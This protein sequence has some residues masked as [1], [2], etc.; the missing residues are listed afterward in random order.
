MIEYGQ[1]Y[2]CA[3]GEPPGDCGQCADADYL[4]AFER[5][6]DARYATGDPSGSPDAAL[7]RLRAA[8]LDT[9]GL[10]AIPEPEPLIDGVLYRDGLAWLAGRPAHGKT[11]IA[12]DVAGS[13][14]TGLPWH[15]YPVRQ[16][17]V[18]YLIAE[19][20]RGIRPRVRAWETAAKQAMAGVTFLPVAVQASN[21][22]YWRALCTLA[23]ELRPAL[24]VL[25]TQARVSVGMEENSAKDMGVL[26][27]RLEELR[28][29]CA[30]CVLTLHHTPRDGNHI[31]GSTALEGA[32]QTVIRVSKEGGVLTL[33]NDPDEGGKQKDAE[34]FDPIHLRIVPSGSSVILTATDRP[35]Q[36]D[37][38]AP[39][40]RDMLSRWWQW[41]GSEP[42]S[43]A[44]LV[45]SGATSER[46]FHRHKKAL[47]DKAWITK[48]GA[49]NATKYA[50]VKDPAE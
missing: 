29:A 6:Q 15:A 7:V 11:L 26:V 24:V 12:L 40:I 31:R 44:V 3:H 8:L 17:R 41:H 21:A 16:G 39:A 14:A 45:K 10:D 22:T 49:G 46:T 35:H 30:A 25:D 36:T 28:A 5:E 13:V 48:S 33:T 9:A 42:V 43:V 50:L 1:D 20:A 34:P 23:A 32:A 2:T 4:K 19:G 18:L 27:D 37:V 38:D 47:L